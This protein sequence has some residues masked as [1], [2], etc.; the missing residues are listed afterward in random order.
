MIEPF[1]LRDLQA[2]RLPSEL[3]GYPAMKRP[4]SENSQAIF[5]PMMPM[6]MVQ[7]HCFWVRRQC[8]FGHHHLRGSVRPQP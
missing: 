6:V 2:G 1:G 4:L 3:F 7:R 5:H 8:F